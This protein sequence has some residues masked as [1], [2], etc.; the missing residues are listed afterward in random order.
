LPLLRPPADRPL[1]LPPLRPA[2]RLPPP[3]RPPADR[4][5]PPLRPRPAD[6]L[7]PPL[8]PPADRPLRLP[9]PLRPPADLPP[10]R[11][12]PPARLPPEGGRSSASHPASSPP[13][14]AAWAVDPGKAASSTNITTTEASV[15]HR[16]RLTMVMAHLR[17]IFGSS[18]KLSQDS[19]DT[20][21]TKV[22]PPD[23]GK[24]CQSP[25]GSRVIF[26]LQRRLGR[27]TAG[28]RTI[29]LR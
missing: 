15:V 17:L 11:L 20:P 18:E 27:G 5:P 12:P 7:P 22:L 29:K 9:P 3:D 2:D 8:R 13:T 24:K 10:P 25:V 23:H 1:R 26:C 6:R 14:G 19:S 28:P 4:L 21:R 16:G